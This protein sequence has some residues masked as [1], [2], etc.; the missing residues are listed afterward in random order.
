[1]TKHQPFGQPVD[2]DMAGEHADR[3]AYAEDRRKRR[4]AQLGDLNANLAANGAEPLFTLEAAEAMH[5]KALG[6]AVRA[7]ADY[8][9]RFG[10]ALREA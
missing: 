10:R 2:R 6:Q 5:N 1:M 9:V 7:T 8:L 4:L 3:G